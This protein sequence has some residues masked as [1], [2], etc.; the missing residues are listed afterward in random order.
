[1]SHL[2][3]A[4]RRLYHQCQEWD[5]PNAPHVIHRKGH[6]HHQGALPKCAGGTKRIAHGLLVLT[7]G[8]IASQRLRKLLGQLC[9]LSRPS[10]GLSC[11]MSSS[12]RALASESHLVHKEHGTWTGTILFFSAVAQ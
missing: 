5:H 3:L 2:P 12:Y 7:T 8:F 9:W 10:A 1:M 4:T 6:Q 11:F